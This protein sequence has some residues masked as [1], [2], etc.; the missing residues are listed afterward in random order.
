[1]FTVV[2][3]NGTANTSKNESFEKIVTYLFKHNVEEYGIIFV[4]FS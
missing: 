2:H 1:M 3:G 4:G